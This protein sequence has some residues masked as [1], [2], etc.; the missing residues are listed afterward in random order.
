V[1]REHTESALLQTSNI[2]K[3]DVRTRNPCSCSQIDGVR[4]RCFALDT[5]ATSIIVITYVWVDTLHSFTATS[6]L[7]EPFPPSKPAVTALRV[8]GECLPVLF[9]LLPPLPAAVKDAWR[10]LR[11]EPGADE[12]SRGDNAVALSWPKY[13]AGPGENIPFASLS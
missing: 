13:I 7:L 9:P 12:G 2:E 10:Q 11:A 4:Y 5:G 8:C 1:K 3:L 6:C